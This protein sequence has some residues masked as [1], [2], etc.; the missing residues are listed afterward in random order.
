MLNPN[1][2]REVGQAADHVG[3]DQIRGVIVGLVLLVGVSL[4]LL[5][6]RIKPE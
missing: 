1:L 2:A 3:T 5:W 6:G 4:S